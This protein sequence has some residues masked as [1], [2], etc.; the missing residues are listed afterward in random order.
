VARRFVQLA[1]AAIRHAARSGGGDP[2]TLAR[3]ALH[4]AAQR[5]A[6]GLAPVIGKVAPAAPAAAGAPAAHAEILDEADE[7]EL[8]AELMEVTSE[9]E[10]DQFLGGLIKSA[11]RFLGQAVQTPVGRA[12]GG[13][14]KQAAA[15]A[16]PRVAQALGSAVGGDAG[17]DLARSV[18]DK[19]GQAF[20]IG[21]G[22]VDETDAEYEAARRFVRFGAD[23]VR[24][25]LAA[26]GVDPLAA[27]R[28]A[29]AGAARQYAPGLASPYYGPDG[30]MAAGAEEG[31]WIRRGNR[32]ILLG[33]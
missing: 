27:A 20:G 12:I 18:T 14:L 25:A 7:M 26:R 31:R 16:L 29:L 21:A 30:G 15:S 4:L 22:E 17:A 23:A 19:L 33:V 28:Q 3:Q 13:Y 10:V 11:G 9:S 6:P 1:A 2:R 24:R 8:A 32:I 5:Y